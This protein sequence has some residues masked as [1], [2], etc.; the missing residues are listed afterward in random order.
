[1][2]NTNSSSAGAK[3]ANGSDEVTE[4]EIGEELSFVAALFDNANDAK[5]AYNQLKEEQREGLVDVLDAAYIE[6]TDRSRIKVHDHNEWD[7]GAGAV[8]GGVTG[9]IIGLVAG[10]ILVPA[11]IGVLVGGIIGGI[12]EHETSFGFKDLRNLAETLPAGTSALVAVVEDP[13]VM[14]TKNE[15]NRLGGKKTQSG[16]VPKSTTQALRSKPRS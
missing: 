11:A 15:L 5:S 2:A 16:K 7:T 9:A 4:V 1:M 8:A 6:K 3:T 14:V 13:Y 10:A 12:Y